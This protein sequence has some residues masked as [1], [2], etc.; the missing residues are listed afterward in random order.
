MGNQEPVS[1]S[2]SDGKNRWSNLGDWS[3]VLLVCML[4]VGMMMAMVSVLLGRAE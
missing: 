1:N 4:F 3:A 2:R